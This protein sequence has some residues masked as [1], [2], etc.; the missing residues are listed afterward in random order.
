MTDSK[1]PPDAMKPKDSRKPFAALRR[2]WR[3][4]KKLAKASTFLPVSDLAQYRRLIVGDD[5]PL[6]G[7]RV[8]GLGGRR[9]FARPGTEDHTTLAYV[10]RERYH[11]P[12]AYLRGRPVILDLGCNCGYTIAHYKHLYP[13]A[14]VIGVEM[15]AEN[16]AVALRNT[17]GLDHVDL[18]QAAVSH[19]DGFVSYSKL[20]KEDA[21][22]VAPTDAGEPPSI[23]PES[24]S[25]RRVQAVSIPSLLERWGLSTVDF[26]KIDIEGE[27]VRLFD[28]AN[29]LGWLDRLQSLNM[30]VHADSSVLETMLATLQRHGFRAWKD[31]HHWSAIMAVKN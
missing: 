28:E 23:T 27:E 30:E 17:Q 2:S 22:R 25:T 11:L 20:A 1:N 9:V 26:A 8:R 7:V 29:G 19:A 5:R 6:I 10:F 3:N 21:Y 13:D 18:I 24:G 12:P 31:A 16:F 14:R 4:L 15:D